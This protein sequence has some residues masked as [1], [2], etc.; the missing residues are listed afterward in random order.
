MKQI[1]ITTPVKILE[2]NELTP[3]DQELVTAAREATKR[4]YAPYS[5]FHV[6]AALLLSNGQVVTGSNQENAAF[7]SG[8][9]AERAA[10]F[11]AHSNYP[12]LDFDTIAVAACDHDGEVTNPISPCGHCRQALLEFEK[13]AKKD[14]RVILIG[15]DKIYI[16]PSIKSLLPLAFTEF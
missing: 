9:C 6:G 12:D 14:M 8:T 1:D 11:W 15:K 3:Q 7:T 13:I 2:Y 10:C 4:S 16:L 5:H